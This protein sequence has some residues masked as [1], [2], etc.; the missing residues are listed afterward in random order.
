MSKENQLLYEFG[1]FRLDP[2]AGELW[3]GAER[4]GLPPKVFEI[5]CV[6]AEREGATVS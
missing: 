6:L 2:A 5:L 4:V 1:E 3:R